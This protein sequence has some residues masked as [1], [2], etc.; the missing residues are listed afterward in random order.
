MEQLPLSTI[1]RWFAGDGPDVDVVISTRTRLARNC[2]GIPFPGKASLFERKQLFEEVTAA[3]KQSP[4]YDDFDYINC[5]QLNKTEQ[6]YLVEERLISQ[7]LL[8]TEGDRGVVCDSSHRTCIMI[9][10]EDHLRM[11]CMDSGCRPQDLWAVIDGIDD[12]LGMHLDFAFD[13]KRGFL[14]ARP[15]DSG[16]GLRV[17]FLMHLPALILTKSIDQVLL[18]ASHLGVSARGFFGEN[19]SVAG[20]FF[21]LSNIATIG[22]AETEFLENTTRVIS[23]TVEAERKARER[24]LHHA[25]AELCDKIQRAF[26]ILTHATMLDVDEFLNLSSAIRLGVECNLFNPITLPLL[27]QLTLCILPAHLQTYHKKTMSDDELKVA[28]ANMVR[29]FFKLGIT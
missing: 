18:A 17:S 2:R 15:T 6:N 7:E 13:A 16:T 12:A 3:F 22:S 26:G 20:S 28:R 27:N 25:Q 24:I 1:P 29:M 14:T 10:E 19:S 21:Q 5:T 4:Q 11:Q 9:N 23:K 8:L